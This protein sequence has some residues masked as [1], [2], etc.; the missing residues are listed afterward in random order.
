MLINRW[1]ITTGRFGTSMGHNDA[2]FRHNDGF[3][4]F[5]TGVPPARRFGV[6]T[7]IVFTFSFSTRRYGGNEDLVL[8]N[9]KNTNP[10]IWHFDASLFWRKT[11]RRFWSDKTTRRKSI[12]VPRNDASFCQNDARVGHQN[13]ASLC[14]YQFRVPVCVEGVWRVLT[15]EW[16]RC[17]SGWCRRYLKGPHQCV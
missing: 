13:D 4:E 5:S 17:W 14:L 8:R 16:R 2:S 12:T 11:T 9:L 15:R 7:G 6:S 1:V 10:P 3:I